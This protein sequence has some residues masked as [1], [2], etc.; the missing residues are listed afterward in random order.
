MIKVL[1]TQ[2]KMSM[3]KNFYGM[4]EATHSMSECISQTIH[5]CSIYRSRMQTP[6]KWPS[7][8]R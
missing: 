5:L 6:N 8:I 4:N 3:N 1:E 2:V 7:F